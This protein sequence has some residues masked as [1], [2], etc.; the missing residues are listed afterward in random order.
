MRAVILAAGTLAI[1]A[2]L[3]PVRSPAVAVPVA[4]SVPREPPFVDAVE[5]W[6]RTRGI[7]DVT[8]AATAGDRTGASA[9]A[10]ERVPAARRTVRILYRYGV[11]LAS[12]T[13]QLHCTESVLCLSCKRQEFRF[14]LQPFTSFC[15][16]VQACVA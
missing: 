9:A 14:V 4:T 11:P 7:G 1:A 13:A 6:L 12:S 5:A 15:L 10:R 2:A 3:A 16:Q 8:G